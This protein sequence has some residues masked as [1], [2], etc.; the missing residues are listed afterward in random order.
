MAGSDSTKV[1]LAALI[2]N[3]LITVAKG[4]AAVVTGSGAML[5]ET[6]HSLADTGN[7]GL[8]LYGSKRA[9]RPPDA[10]HPFGYG[11]EKYFWA[12]IVALL[13]FSM[14]ALFSLYEGV[15]K[16]RHPQELESVSWAVGVLIFAFVVEGRVFMVARREV[17]KVAGDIGFWRFF[18]ESKDPSLPLVYL[19]DFGAMIGLVF[20]MIGI[21]GSSL[22]GWVYADGIAT[23]CIGLLLG[24]IAG[25]LLRRCH[26]LLIG[27]SATIADARKILDIVHSVDGI[28]E[29][30]ELKTLQ[31]GPQYLIV[32]LEV[33]VTGSLDVLDVLEERI[34]AEVP[35]AKYV[36]IEPATH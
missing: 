30:V 36:A 20:A 16:L 34:R 24:A 14:G 2:G 17:R 35:I 4:V 6:I 5:A 23:I 21:A 1:V 31:V 29:V 33:R 26:R 22:F 10:K 3:F 9:K 18:A 7:Q 12:F 15:H 13:L 8:L 28:G 27:E 32:G 25:V 19:E 11:S